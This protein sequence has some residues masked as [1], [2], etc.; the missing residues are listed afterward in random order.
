MARE[1]AEELAGKGVLAQVNVDDNPRLAARFGA[2]GVPAFIAFK[3]GNVVGNLQGALPK[4]RLSD[5]FQ[6]VTK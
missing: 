5:W 3:G 1:V 2:S 4:K 6:G